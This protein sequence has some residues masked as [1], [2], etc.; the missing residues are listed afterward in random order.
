LTSERA[1]KE[2]DISSAIPSP[3][4]VNEEFL[5]TEYYKNFHKG[6]YYSKFFD[7]AAKK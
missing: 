7:D 2:D 1:N 3:P 6:N 4:D 5:R